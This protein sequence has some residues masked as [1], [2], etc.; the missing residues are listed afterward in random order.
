MSSRRKR[1]RASERRLADGGKRAYL[2]IWAAIVVA[3]VALVIGVARV[4]R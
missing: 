3:L 2:P 1:R 4:T